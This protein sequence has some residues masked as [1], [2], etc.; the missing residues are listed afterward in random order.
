MGPAVPILPGPRLT[1]WSRLR[2]QTI[3]EGVGTQLGRA[4]VG[5][6]L[7]ARER[8][9]WSSLRHDLGAL[10]ATRFGLRQADHSSETRHELA[11]VAGPVVVATTLLPAWEEP[12][13]THKDRVG[14]DRPHRPSPDGSAIFDRCQA[15]VPPAGFVEVATTPSTDTATQRDDDWHDTADSRSKNGPGGTAI[16]IARQV[17]GPPVGFVE[18][19]IPRPPRCRPTQSDRPTHDRYSLPGNWLVVVRLS[20]VCRV[21]WSLHADE[22]PVGREE[23]TNVSWIVR[24]R[25][26]PC[27]KPTH[28]GV[29]VQDSAPSSSS[30]GPGPPGRCRPVNLHDPRA[31]GFVE[32]TTPAPVAMAGAVQSRTLEQETSPLATGV[33]ALRRR[34]V[35]FHPGLLPAGLVEAKRSPPSSAATHSERDRDARHD[36]PIQ[37][38]TAD[39]I[40]TVLQPCAPPVGLVVLTTWPHC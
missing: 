39:P 11:L 13:A 33:D 7:P 36:R 32:V 40:D 30:N 38:P 14:H 20:A 3:I 4:F 1:V 29:A 8:L 35:A 12:T 28:S 9:G 23:V 5:P 26:M 27:E 31:L 16:G 34:R 22:P 18:T 6:K 24:L 21:V 37:L 15:L 19:T 2:D 25:G 17:A 10:A